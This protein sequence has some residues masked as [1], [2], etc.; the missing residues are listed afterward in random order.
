MD[1]RT[2]E[3]R[4]LWDMRYGYG[5]WGVSERD[6]TWDGEKEKLSGGVLYERA[7]N[8]VRVRRPRRISRAAPT[9]TMHKNHS[10]LAQGE[11]CS[12]SDDVSRQQR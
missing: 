12:S 10:K 9:Y 11:I 6:G 5:E 4:K 3:A 2:G 8:Q 7:V 1:S